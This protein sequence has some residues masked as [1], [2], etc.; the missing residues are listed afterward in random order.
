M[1][2]RIKKKVTLYV[3]QFKDDI[4]S[5][6]NEVDINKDTMQEITTYVTNYGRL[7]FNEEDF[8]KRKR[9]KNH[10]PEHDRCI[11]KRSDGEQCTRRKKDTDNYCGT[12]QKCRPHGCVVGTVKSRVNLNVVNNEGIMHYE[13]DGGRIYR[14][15]GVLLN[16]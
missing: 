9:V 15:E 1:E 4:V 7:N 10:V 8:S 13:S 12:H 2:N 14:A 11:A 5:K 3:N 16:S 6:M